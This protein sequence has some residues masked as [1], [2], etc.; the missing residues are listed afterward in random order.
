MLAGVVTFRARW[1]TVEANGSMQAGDDGVAAD[2]PTTLHAPVAGFQGDGMT[3]DCVRSILRLLAVAI[4]MVGLCMAAYML[5]G[6]L[7]ASRAMSG[8]SA[9]AQVQ[10]SGTIAHLGIV[11]VLADLAVSGLGL[12]LFAISPSLAAKIVS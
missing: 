6:F 11:A 7:G 5:I 3:E 4:I 8:M 12:G 2:R 1:S 10:M 9:G